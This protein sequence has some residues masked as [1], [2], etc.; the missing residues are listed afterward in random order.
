MQFNVERRA[1]LLLVSVLVITLGASGA[2]AG[3]VVV[4]SPSLAEGV[5]E[6]LSVAPN[7]HSLIAAASASFGI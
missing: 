5:V 6:E 1:A 2:S 4:F 7:Y 3:R